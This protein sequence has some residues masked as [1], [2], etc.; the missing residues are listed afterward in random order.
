[1]PRTLPAAAGARRGPAK[2]GA[3]RGSE[4]LQGGAPGTAEGWRGWPRDAAPEKT[5]MKER[6]LRECW[7]GTQGTG[8]A[9]KSQCPGCGQGSGRQPMLGGEAESAEAPGARLSCCATRVPPAGDSGA[10]GGWGK[11]WGSRI[12]PLCSV[13]SQSQLSKL[14]GL[15]QDS[16]RDR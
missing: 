15:R 9:A 7:R 8:E 10:G 4:R 11:P 2:R 6:R 3:R 14:P 1:M 13:D 5:G 16:Q 12:S